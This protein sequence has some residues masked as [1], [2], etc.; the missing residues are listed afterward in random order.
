[1]IRTMLETARTLRRITHP[2][3]LHLALPD[4]GREGARSLTLDAAKDAGAILWS[5]DLGLRN[6][7]H[8][9]GVNAFGTSGSW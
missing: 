2:A 1:V 5:D 4:A 3:L 9:I 6:A 8:Q 7:A